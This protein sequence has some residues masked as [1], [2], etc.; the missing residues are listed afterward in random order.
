MNKKERKIK[1][2]GAEF[3]CGGVISK[4]EHDKNVKKFG[5]WADAMY[6]VMPD[7]QYQLYV[8]AN[9]K[10]DEKEAQKLFKKFAISQI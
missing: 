6:W 9:K 5:V 2:L 7:A 4:S 1:E 3:I 8:V 10:G